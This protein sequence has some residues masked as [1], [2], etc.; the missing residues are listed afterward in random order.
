L[1]N[2]H[3]RA[4]LA[5]LVAAAAAPHV[6]ASEQTRMRVL[7][8]FASRG[9][10]T[11]LTRAMAE[12]GHRDGEN[13]RFD[14]RQHAGSE[15]SALAEAARQLVAARPDVLVALWPYEISALLA[16]THSIPIVCGS[17]PD[18]VGAGFARSL[19]R[20]GGNVTG[21]S[22]GSHET[23][24]LV[25]GMLRTLRP[26]LRRI[27]VIH[28][29]GMPVAIQMRTHR[30]AAEAAGISWSQVAVSTP[31]EVERALAPLA[32]EALHMAPIN[33][34]GLPA[35]LLDIAHRH[36]I[37]TFGGYPGTLMGYSRYFADEMQRI[38]ATVDKVLRGAN[39]AE[40][41][42]EL[43]DRTS[44]VVNRVVARRIGVEIPP[45]MLLRATEVIDS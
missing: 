21:L 17:I 27:A 12:L 16:A 1:V 28:S 45:D 40:I 44:F 29:P 13:L 26:R 23:W 32:G 25:I 8:C 34:R 30:E 19:R 2:P 31:E 11:P 3:R 15:A 37:L 7:G 10:A 6:L 42:F 41:P 5:A 22:T 33:V 39:P 36:R 9:E 4:L 14:V 18:P 20:P 43:P 35:V 24:P 38:A